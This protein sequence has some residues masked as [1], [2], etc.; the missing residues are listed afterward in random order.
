MSQKNLSSFPS[1]S[2][3]LKFLKQLVR[4]EFWSMSR[5]RSRKSSSR[6]VTVSHL[7]AGM[8]G[9]DFRVGLHSRD[10]SAGRG[11]VRQRR[12]KW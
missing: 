6:E 12:R 8:T 3:E 2:V 4:D 5:L 11:C 9:P 7:R 1:V 10:A